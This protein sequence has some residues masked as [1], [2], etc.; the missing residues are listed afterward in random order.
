MEI[1][2]KDLFTYNSIDNTL[3]IVDPIPEDSLIGKSVLELTIRASKDNGVDAF[4]GIVIVIEAEPP[5]SNVNILFEKSLY[6]G[7]YL[8]TSEIIVVETIK[9][10]LPINVADVTI[11]LDGGMYMN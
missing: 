9:I 1:V 3:S 7:A 10:N 5:V 4:A 8:L 2:D 11:T 6:T